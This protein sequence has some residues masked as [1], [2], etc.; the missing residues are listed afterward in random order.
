MEFFAIELFAIEQG[1]K[2]AGYR[3]GPKGIFYIATTRNQPA[4]AI[5]VIS[6]G[7]NSVRH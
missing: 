1:G 5:A 2:V 6:C 3:I 7:R 4:I